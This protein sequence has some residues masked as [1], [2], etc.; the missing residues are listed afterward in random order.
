M[1]GGLDLETR[2]MQ[3]H[4]RDQKVIFNCNNNARMITISA[5]IRAVLDEVT[6][7]TKKPKRRMSKACLKPMN[8][9]K[10]HTL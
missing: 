2:E 4:C 1:A 5:E 7:Q 6:E 8:I 9:P 3:T 10:Y